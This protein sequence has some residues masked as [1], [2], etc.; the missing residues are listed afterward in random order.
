MKYLVTRSQN[1]RFDP[2]LFGR[3]PQVA[4]ASF[5]V[6]SASGLELIG[7]QSTKQYAF[8][9]HELSSVIPGTSL[10]RWAG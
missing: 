3:E 5:K 2:P 6:V 4:H 7:G 9:K 8:G 10:L 1:V